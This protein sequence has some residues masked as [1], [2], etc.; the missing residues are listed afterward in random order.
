MTINSETRVAGP[1]DGNDS[2]VFFP[3]TFK[4]FD[5]DEVRVVAETGA[6][7]TDLELGT[8]YTVTLNADQ[9]AAPGGSV[10]L[11]NPLATGTRLT[12]TSALEM[13]QPVDLTNQG[14]FYPR[15]INSALD[16]LTILLQQLA[17]VVSRTLKFPLSDGPVGDL[18]GRSA[19]AG[20][21]LAFDEATGEPVAGPDIASVNGVVG[22]LVAINTVSDNIVDV[23]TVADNIAD[24]NTVSDNIAD[25]NT[26]A[27]SIT[28]VNTVAGNIADVN[29][30]ADN[31]TDLSN[32]SGVYYGPSATDPT[33]RRDGSP[34]QVGDLYFSTVTNAMRAYNGS[35]WRESVTGAVTVQNLSGDGVETE[36]LLDYAPES[37]GITNVFISGVYQQK[38]TY[39][40]GGANG[41]VLIFDEA[42]PA[43]TDNIEVVVSSLVPSDDKLRQELSLDAS[44]MIGLNGSTL[45]GFY[46]EKV[47]IESFGAVPGG[48]IAD[49][50]DAALAALAGTDKVLYL[51]NTVYK[52]SRT[53]RL[54]GL[55]VYS[56][57]CEIQKDFDGVGIEIQGGADYFDLEG[58]LYLRGTGAGFYDPT[59]PGAVPPANPNAHGVWFNSAR[60]RIR[61][62]IICQYHQGDLY[63][64]TCAGN[65]NKTNIDALWGW[66]GGRGVYFEGTQDDF[67]VC[68][69][70]LF[71]QFTWGSGIATSA[72]FM[73]RDWKGFWYSENAALD[74]VSP[75]MDIKKLRSS[76][77]TIYCEQ[78]NTAREVVLGAA[79]N[80]NTI[81]SFRHNKD[82]DYAGAAGNNTWLDGGWKYNP[83]FPGDTRTA[84]PSIIRGDRVRSNTSGEYVA[85][86]FLGG[87]ALLGSVRGEGG[88]TSP[89]IKLVSAN[90]GS[91]IALANDDFSVTI[92]GNRALK[93]SSTGLTL[94]VGAFDVSGTTSGKEVDVTTTSLKSSRNSTAARDHLEFYNPNGKVGGISTSATATTYATSS[95][96]RLKENIEEADSASVVID[97]IQVVQYDWLADGSHEDWGVVAQQVAEVYPRAVTETDQF[98]VDYSKFVPLLI[99]EVQELRAR[100]AS[101]EAPVE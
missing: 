8:D 70:N 2:T 71:M 43:G 42:P 33:T 56:D 5:A 37:E 69:I 23:N 16:R 97:A 11:A 6:V 94:G 15:V 19:R 50:C 52:I 44:G 48:D 68:E 86:T 7:E 65:M 10:V 41:D 58:T 4:V 77:L 93:W 85:Q 91:S 25:V 13:L 72:D 74:G 28:D 81:R 83:G 26:V 95:D 75:G 59:L 64:F 21:V 84:T 49:A 89:Y 62:K 3:F 100:V 92:A 45:R 22:A 47:S 98:M 55:N 34:L 29:T 73:G 39:D 88:T 12:L 14:G 18:P 53:I 35:A 27:G 54:D 63:R 30:V 96:R 9:N 78:Q 79:C 36:F 51:P 32:F 90:G 80:R 40:L 99:K 46:G 20:T 82:D 101:L 60:I 61:G 1:F 66:W 57:G 24:V 38:N 31:I 87:S 17:S 67:S 76:D